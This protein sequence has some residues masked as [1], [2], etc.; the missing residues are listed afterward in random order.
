MCGSITDCGKLEFLGA[1][2]LFVEF[3]CAE[4]HYD[5]SNCVEYIEI[6]LERAR[7]V[8]LV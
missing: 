4:C 5:D 8:V 3:Y 2:C 7:F 1:K 6:G